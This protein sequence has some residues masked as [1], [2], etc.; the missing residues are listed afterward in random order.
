MK[1][2]S[3]FYRIFQQAPTLLFDL[4][5]SYPVSAN[6]YSFD[7]VE[8]KQTSFRIDGVF[9]PPETSG[10]AYFAEVQFQPDQL[11]YERI[12]SEASMYFYR[13][14]NRCSDY[15]LVVIYP[16]QALEQDDLDP[17]QYLIQTGKLTRI[18][19]DQLGSV[20]QLPIGL[21]LMVLT[22]LED[23]E[24]KQAAL[25]LVERS[26]GNPDE[27]AIM[28]LISTILIYKFTELT[29]DEVNAMLASSIQESRAYWEI[30]AEGKAEIILKQLTLVLKTEIPSELKQRIESFT[31]DRLDVLSEVLLGFDQLEDLMQWLEVQS[32]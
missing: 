22:T 23:D 5:Q 13:N 30:K 4:L 24:A 14:R 9:L 16:S 10:I 26:Q 20:S 29:R 8:V 11:L 31:N 15:R 2:D 19:L 3:L 7:S 6:G 27:H 1:R 32:S 25:Q 28:D 21:G 17:H 12:M 18:Y